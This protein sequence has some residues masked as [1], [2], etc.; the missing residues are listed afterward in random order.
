[1]WD[2]LLHIWSTLMRL[3]HE[4]GPEHLKVVMVTVQ[5]EHSVT[6]KCSKLIL[7]AI[8]FLEG[9][10]GRGGDGISL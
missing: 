8:C 6:W 7:I 4:P 2:I 5:Y 10:G 1:M 9:G 3:Y